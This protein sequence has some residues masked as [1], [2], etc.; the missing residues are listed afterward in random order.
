MSQVGSRR[1]RAG[2][3]YDVGSTIYSFKTLP[4]DGVIP[5][6]SPRAYRS[7]RRS[8]LGS[9]HSPHLTTFGSSWATAQLLASVCSCSPPWGAAQSRSHIANLASPVHL[10]QSHSRLFGDSLL[11]KKHFQLELFA[12]RLRRLDWRG[13]LR[14]EMLP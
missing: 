2:Q 3:Y 13:C 8:A 7:L 5:Q 10:R 9:N 1:A 11:E 14:S 6:P 4:S 12:R